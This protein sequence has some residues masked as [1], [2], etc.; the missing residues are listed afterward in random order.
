MSTG[1]SIIGLGLDGRRFS[2]P[3][4]AEGQRKLGG[5]ENEVLTNGDG[6][7]RLIKTR[8]P[9][10]LDGITVSIDDDRGDA[11][12]LQELQNR[13]GFFPIVVT[14]ASGISYQGS[15]QITGETQ[16]S[17]QSSTSSVSLMGP[18][19]LTRQ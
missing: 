8:V 9:L 18:G 11:E 5:W 13:N 6:T 17:S 15:A 16:I 14:F 2:V 12:Y 7:A 1:G 3:S 4:D 19:T 10:Q